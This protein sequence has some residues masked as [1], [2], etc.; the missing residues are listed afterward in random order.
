M[1]SIRDFID[2]IKSDKS[3]ALKLKQAKSNAQR[4]DIAKKM[5]FNFTEKNLKQAKTELSNEELSL[6]AGSGGGSY[7]GITT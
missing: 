5:G 4:L 3:L 6:I 2:K 1:Q 7:W